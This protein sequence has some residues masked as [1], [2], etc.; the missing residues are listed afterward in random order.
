MKTV[1]DDS[2]KREYARTDAGHIAI[3]KNEAE[4]LEAPLR[5]GSCH[6]DFNA[7][8]YE[9]MNF[10]RKAAAR[11]LRLAIEEFERRYENRR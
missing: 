4:N 10:A 8:R 6:C 9:E 3:L 5:P 11:V 1:D 7:F 2:L